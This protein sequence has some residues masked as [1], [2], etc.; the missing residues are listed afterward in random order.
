[1]ERMLA[2][3]EPVCPEEGFTA[4]FHGETT[5]L[6]GILVQLEPIEQEMKL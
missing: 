5:S 4:I 3:F 2:C 1:M 6:A